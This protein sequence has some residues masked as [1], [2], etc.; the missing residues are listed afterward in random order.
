MTDGCARG[1]LTEKS[2]VNSAAGRELGKTTKRLLLKIQLEG[3]LGVDEETW[4]RPAFQEERIARV[5][6]WNPES[7]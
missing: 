6:A 7:S 4:R 3:G 1:W 5:K 2:G